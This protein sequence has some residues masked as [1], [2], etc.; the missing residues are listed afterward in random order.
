MSN[1]DI[2]RT[3][4]ACRLRKAIG[5]PENTVSDDKLLRNTEGSKIRAQIELSMALQNLKKAI[6]SALPPVLRRLFN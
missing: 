3:E 5:I 6:K 4:L 1:P 2:D